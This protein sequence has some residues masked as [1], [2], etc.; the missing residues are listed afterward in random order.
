MLEGQV[1]IFQSK[2]KPI[3]FF[4][5]PKFTKQTEQLFLYDYFFY[6]TSI[7]QNVK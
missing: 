1:P 7:K 3:F 2:L 6:T 4:T 5:L